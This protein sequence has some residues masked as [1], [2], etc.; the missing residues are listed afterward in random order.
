LGSR[1]FVFLGTIVEAFVSTLFAGMKMRGCYQFRVTRNSD[2]FVEQ[3]E[4]DDLLRAVEGELASR[5]YGDAVRLETA[6]DCPD[7]ILAYLLEQFALTTDDL[8]KVSG[9]VNLNRLMFSTLRSSDVLL[10]HP[11]QGFGPVTEFV[12]QAASDP[13]V[14]AIKQTLYRVG[15]DSAI[16]VALVEAAAAGKDVTVIIELRA[17]FDE[18]ANIELATKLQEAG[19]HVMYGVFG[20][21]THA[22]LVMVVRREEKGLRRYC[23]LGTG[24]YHTK[25]ARL[26]TDYGLLTA[27]ESIGEDIHEIFLQL[28][29]LTQVPKLRKL[30]HAPFSLHQ[31][32][33]AKIEREAEHA[34]AGKPARI[35]AKLNALTEPAIIQALYRASRAGVDIELIIRGVCCLRPGVR[36]VSERIKVRSI[37]GRFLEHSRVYYFEN[38]GARE[39]YCGSADWMDR[40][41]FRRIEIAFPIE[42]EELKDRVTDDL[43]LY[44]QDDM[45]AWVLD[46]DGHYSRA[47]V[48]GQV[49]AQLRLMNLYDERVALTEG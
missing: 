25:T 42:G 38:A 44:L 48:D 14:L 49:S 13:Q 35:I 30:L 3:E 29:G 15:S 43:K 23:H 1:N 39:I 10:H 19:A 32:L 18:E 24:N 28:T 9:P 5:R 2:L 21:K 16:V 27:D 20:F 40:N 8:Y 12:R 37:V 36:G 45:Q 11:F 31:A 17:R 33:L 41:L 47:V 34:R 26:Y 6:H 4:V 22:K 46:T 7:E